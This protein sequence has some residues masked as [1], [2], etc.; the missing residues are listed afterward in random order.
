MNA[1]AI[2]DDKTDLFL[3]IGGSKHAISWSSVPRLYAT[4]E[5]ARRSFGAYKGQNKNYKDVSQMKIVEIGFVRGT[6]AL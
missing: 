2:Y 3:T 4:I 6:K 1:F 5:E